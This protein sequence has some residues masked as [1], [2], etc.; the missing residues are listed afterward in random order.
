MYFFLFVFVFFIISYI[1]LNSFKS[2]T[3]ICYENSVENKKLV[4][5]LFCVIYT[6]ITGLQFDVGTDYFSYTSLFLGENIELYERKKEYGF[7]Y[8]CLFISKY[9]IHPQWGFIILSCI[10]YIC[11]YKFL[12]FL[13]LR[14]YTIF[15]YLYFTVCVFLYNQTNIIRQYTVAAILL[16]S[17]KNFYDKKYIAM[18]VEVLI[19][20]LFHS[21]AFLFFPVFLVMKIILHRFKGYIWIIYL[22]ISVIMIRVNVVSFVIKSIPFLSRY[23]HYMDSLWGT[24]QISVIN[25]MTKI[26]YLPFYFFSLKSLS[27]MV[28]KKDIFLFQ[29]GIFSYGICLSSP[30]LNRFTTYFE[31]FTIFPLYYLLYSFFSRGIKISY[32]NQ[33]FLFLFYSITIGLLYLK[34]VIMPSAEYDYKSI[35]M[36]IFEGKYIL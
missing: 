14:S 7:Y 35:F 9:K 34:T 28:E 22:L 29:L 16:L 6:F 2:L 20:S 1:Q 4:L 21:S 17:V 23:S 25:I 15:F 27:K 26:I 11:I 31:I 12:K 3:T 33:L 24:N 19:A 8:L 18:F 5:I 32:F 30:I 10:Q 13:N 36:A